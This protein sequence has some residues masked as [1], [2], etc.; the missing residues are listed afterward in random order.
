M[1]SR[2][3]EPEGLGVWQGSRSSLRLSQLKLLE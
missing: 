3:D 1:M 2:K